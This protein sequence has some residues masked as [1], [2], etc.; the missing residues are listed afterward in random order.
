MPPIKWVWLWHHLQCNPCLFAT[1]LPKCICKNYSVWICNWIR[2]FHVFC[3]KIV[4]P[5]LNDH[6][7]IP[8]EQ[9]ALEMGHGQGWS[10]LKTGHGQGLCGGAPSPQATLVISRQAWTRPLDA[11]R[12][13]SGPHPASQSHNLQ[14]YPTLS[15]QCR[16][17]AKLDKYILQFKQIH[18][19][20]W[21]N[22]LCNLNKIHL[23]CPILPAQAI[24]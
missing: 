21:T 6:P 15:F 12:A 1:H 22:T 8:A 7:Q 18:L 2:I 17:L 23:S 10:S 4:K 19:T 13:Y 5:T 11:R 16:C 14:T 20:E 24:T 3:S 9:C